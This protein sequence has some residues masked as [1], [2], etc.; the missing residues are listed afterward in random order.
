MREG[1]GGEDEGKA[2]TVGKQGKE[3]REGDGASGNKE[4]KRKVEEPK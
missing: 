3:N 1:K 2:L 4:E